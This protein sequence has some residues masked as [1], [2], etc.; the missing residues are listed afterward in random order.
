MAEKPILI[1]TLRRTGGTSLAQFLA[2]L[3]GSGPFKHEPFNVDRPFGQVHSAFRE[4]QDRTALDRDIAEVMRDHP[5]VK[6]CID[7]TPYRLSTG[8]I[9]FARDAG[10]RFLV[11]TRRDN[12]RRLLSLAVA[13]STGAWGSRQAAKVYPAIRSGEIKPAPIDIPGLARIM[14]N[15]FHN[16]GVV[17]THLRNNRISHEWIVFED[18]YGGEAPVEVQARELA[19]RFGFDIG[20]DHPLLDTFGKSGGQGTE[21]IT[22]FIPN[23][24]EARAALAEMH[25]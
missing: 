11:L 2:N 23:I 5:N 17:M 19:G 3:P 7:N 9:D 4:T 24:D 12:A 21:T 8:L 20:P 25:S 1:L 15:D 10:Y 16:L 13:Q 22:G 18:F 14:R 6:H